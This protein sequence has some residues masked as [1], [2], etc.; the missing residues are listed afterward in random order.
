ME[1]T[2]NSKALVMTLLF[3]LLFGG[4]IIGLDQYHFNDFESVLIV[5]LI[6]G[7]I[8]IF[9]A[10][11]L[12]G[13]SLGLMGIIGLDVILIILQS[14][15]IIVTLGQ[16]AEPD[17]HDPLSNWWATLLMYS[18]SLLTLIFSIRTYRES[19]G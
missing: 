19:R 8:A 5:L 4:Y 18:F 3:R 2:W 7:L 15:F 11:F 13:I 12:L 14:L 10:L 17:L 16:I 6:Y 1:L 9:T